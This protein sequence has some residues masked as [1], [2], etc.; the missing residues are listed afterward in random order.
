MKS[1]IIMVSVLATVCCGSARADVI[2]DLYFRVPGLGDGVDT[3]FDVSPGQSFTGVEAVLRET[4]TGDSQSALAVSTINGFGINIA[5]TG[6]NGSVSGKVTN[7][8]GGNAAD[9]DSPTTFGYFSFAG[10]MPPSA[11]VGG[12]REV[13][14]GTLDFTAPTIGATTFALVDPNPAIAGDITTFAGPGAAGIESVGTFNTRSITLQAVPEPGALLTLTFTS[15]FVFFR[16]RHSH[17]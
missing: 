6:S 4:I 14:L 8:T 11:D 15:A 12:V 10:G 1:C 17:V 16:R 13:I 7:T 9:S 3:T 5:V 2:Y